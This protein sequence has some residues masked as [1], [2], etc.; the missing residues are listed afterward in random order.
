MNTSFINV[1]KYL[2]S[3]NEGKTNHLDENEKYILAC[4]SNLYEIYV[5]KDFS[6]KKKNISIRYS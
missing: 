3:I 4:S 5:F 1:L 6:N 2:D